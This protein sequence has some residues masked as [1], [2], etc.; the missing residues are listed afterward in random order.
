MAGRRWRAA[1]EMISARWIVA[2]HH[3]AAIW[4]A[5]MCGN[6]GFELGNVVNRCRDSLHC[7]GRSGGFKGVQEIFGVRRRC[8][9]EQE[10]DPGDERRDLLEQLQ[11]LAGHRALKSDETGGV[12]VWSRQARDEAAADRIDN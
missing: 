8:R 10:G 2:N 4:L 9:V 6:D 3:K 11:P 5:C 12:A 7:E 1:T